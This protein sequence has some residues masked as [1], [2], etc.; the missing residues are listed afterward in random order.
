RPS[1][2]KRPVST[3]VEALRTV[4]PPHWSTVCTIYMRGL[5]NVFIF[6]LNIERNFRMMDEEQDGGEER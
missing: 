1:V 2:Y 5:V 4:L 6:A 3:E